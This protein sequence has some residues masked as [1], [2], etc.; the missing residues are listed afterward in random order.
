VCDEQRLIMTA[1]LMAALVFSLYGEE[2]AQWREKHDHH[3]RYQEFLRE[4]VS[5]ATR[6]LAGRASFA[7]VTNAP[8]VRRS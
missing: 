6:H 2:I 4:Q 5:L 3:S 8:L 1:L 7:P